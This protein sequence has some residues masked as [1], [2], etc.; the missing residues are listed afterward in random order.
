MI[1][2]PDVPVFRDPSGILLPKF[3]TVNFVTA[4]APNVYSMEKHGVSLGGLKGLLRDRAARILAVC[5]ENGARVL[6]LGAW[7]CGVF[8]NDPEMVAEVFKELLEG[9]FEGVFE[10]VVFAVYDRSASQGTIAA[11]RSTFG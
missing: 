10:E 9:K 7:G 2:S 11:F 5:A 3:Y 1:W 8:K 4:A 6:V